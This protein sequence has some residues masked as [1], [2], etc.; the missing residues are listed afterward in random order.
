MNSARQQAFQRL[1]TPCVELSSTALKFKADQV[2]P[3]VVLLALEPVYQIL[4]S[5][6]RDGLLDEKLAE[7]AFF[8]LTHIFNQSRRL[9]SHCLELAVKCVN[10]LVSQGWR[11]KLLPEMAKQLLILMGLLVSTSPSQHNE[12]ATDEL[13]VASFECIS[14]LVAQ[15]RCLTIN[16]LEVSSEKNIVDQL[17]YQLLESITET[18]S[19]N[20]Q[21]SAAQA[22]LELN[23]AINDRPFLASLL[24]RTVSTLVKVLRPSTQARRTRKVLAAYLRLLTVVLKGVL[25]DE[26]GSDLEHR[27]DNTK[28]SESKE[29]IVLDKQ[30]R[31]ATTPQ[32]DLALV[33][34]VKLRTHEGSEVGQALLDLCLMV[35]ENAPR[36]LARS[37]PLMVETL[38]VLS[39]SA[40]STAAKAT[41]KHL[42]FSRPEVAEI[43]RAKF[44]DWSQALPRV[45]QGNDDR[46]KQQMLGQVATSFVALMDTSSTTD[47]APSMVASVLV[48]AVAAAIDA[49]TAK[50]KLVDEAPY[51]ATTD[52]VQQTLRVEDFNP[53]ILNHQSQ[54][55]SLKELKSFVEL[56]RSHSLGP[57]LT[58]C[59]LDRTQDPNPSRKLSATYLALSLLRSHGDE[60]ITLDDMIA[61]SSASDLSLSRPFLVADLYAL[62]LPCLLQYS[63][64]RSEDASDWR[65]VAMSLESL[66]LQANQLGQSYRPELVETLFPMLTLLGSRNGMLQRHAMTALN[67]LV[68]V[69]EYGS[70]AQMLIE[71]ADY[72][73]N[74]IAMRLNAFDVSRD[75]LQ[76]L[77][78]M[79]GLC[80]ASL[81]PYLDDLVASIFGALDSFHGYPQLV[82][83]LF[84]MLKLMV[85]KTSAKPDV[86]A[87]NPAIATSEHTRKHVVVSTVDVIL[88]D[89]RMRRR[90]KDSSDEQLEETASTPH[91]PWAKATGDSEKGEEQDSD[92]EED[93]K[94]ED[95]STTADQNKEPPLSKSHQLLL[96]IARSTVPHFS[97]PSPKVRLT[98]LA[99]LREICP[100]L[101]QHENSFLPLVSSIW[102][103]VVSRLLLWKEDISSEMPYNAQ[104]AVETMTIICSS[105]GDFMSSRIE[106]VFSDLV[107]IFTKVSSAIVP[108]AK[109]KSSKLQ[110][111]S[112][113]ES[114]VDERRNIV[115]A[116]DGETREKSVS[117]L[118]QGPVTRPASMQMLYS[119]IALFVSILQNVRV[120][121]DSADMIFDILVPFT[122][123]PGNKEVNRE[124][125]LEYNADALWLIE[126]PFD[127]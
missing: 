114:V 38:V 126:Q 57:A 35:I 60:F 69:C 112:Q 70:V 99:L 98:L 51:F 23:H 61:D 108:S 110:N 32:V 74:G 55:A 113:L 12:P 82:E 65:L 100:P 10:I 18:S 25:A 1:R 62:T 81:I 44:Y 22:L 42:M 101:A 107:A 63:E 97:S 87:I 104:A 83:D 17:V 37:L 5:L 103:A 53:V 45:M 67:L 27:P 6:A 4:Q 68:R 54:Q 52:L 123:L 43:V 95:V 117:G 90:R 66:I 93:L 120:T 2:S 14:V 46:P 115:H 77:A 122:G 26:M 79:I 102:P 94:D 47:E 15:S 30:W 8:P 86:L 125:L 20:V 56:L 49:G 13:K 127:G 109:P 48:E 36:T 41:L 3:K 11:D 71:N 124:I 34:V 96:N 80:G 40:S 105:A 111:G 116:D 24:P 76:V 64:S 118:L 78:M 19:D 84:G 121:Q 88:E 50:N 73:I 75:G 39:Q 21:I 58:R 72:L 9:S 85:D 89:L 29:N 59:M 91:R 92:G 119:V 16:V 28:G 31:D 106:E 7:Y 33:Q